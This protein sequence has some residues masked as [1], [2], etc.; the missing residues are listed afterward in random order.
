MS[1]DFHLA[2]SIQIVKVQSKRESRSIISRNDDEKNQQQRIIFPSFGKKIVTRYLIFT[3][4]SANIKSLFPHG[5]PAMWKANCGNFMALCITVVEQS[6]S[7]FHSRQAHFIYLKSENIS[8]ARFLFNA[9][10]F[11]CI[12]LSILFFF[13]LYHLKTFS[14]G[15][16]KTPAIDIMNIVREYRWYR[17]FSTILITLCSL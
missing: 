16:R 6:N 8:S 10:I 15:V 13:F 17:A 12:L 11:S 9:S 1:G 5:E 2:N 4:I 7:I 3:F 14:D